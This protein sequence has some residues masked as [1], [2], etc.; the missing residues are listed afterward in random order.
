MAEISGPEGTS[1]SSP[2]RHVHTSAAP[3][4]VSLHDKHPPLDKK[5]SDAAISLHITD[6]AAHATIHASPDSSRPPDFYE[7]DV[8]EQ[9]T[10]RPF[11]PP[12]TLVTNTSTGTTYHPQVYYIFSDDEP[13]TLTHALQLA[14]NR[15]PGLYDRAVIVDLQPSDADT[16]W[17]V[18]A[19][20][21]ITAD[22]AVTSA[23][24]MPLGGSPGPTSA[25]GG[26]ST[27]AA[28]GN[29]ANNGSDSDGD[30]ILEITGTDALLPK[31]VD[32]LVEHFPDPQASN[33]LLEPGAKNYAPIVAEFD[34]CMKKLSQ[35]VEAGEANLQ[36]SI[37][38]QQQQQQ[39]QNR[40]DL[41]HSTTE[42]PRRKDS[43]NVTSADGSD[44][45][46]KGKMPAY[47]PPKSPV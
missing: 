2:S 24:F 11:D 25:G 12:L 30:M 32:V 8:H 29:A 43:T 27:A 19:A 47:A 13:D 16:G 39:Q 4:P 23:Q 21:S 15:N 22:W 10:V 17:T 5:S 33:P 1:S 45:R 35:V 28:S 14:N 6:A 36:H 42:G 38:V 34:E 44:V 37:R 20:S 41:M 7:P 3:S 40:L 9:E 46:G 26:M 18:A 31:S